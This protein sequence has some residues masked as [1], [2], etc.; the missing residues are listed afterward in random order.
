MEGGTQAPAQNGTVELAE[1]RTLA[2]KLVDAALD[3]E[4]VQ[5]RGRND[6][7]KYDYAR[8]ED[9]ANAAAKALLKHRVL[10]DFEFPR[11][12]H[13]PIKSNKGT[14]G[15]L[16]TVH[17]HLIATDADSGEQIIRK[18]IG[19]GSDYPGDKAAYKAMTGARKY[20]LTHLLGIP[21]GHD[22]DA[23]AGTGR[24]RREVARPKLPDSRVA[25]LK[26]AFKKRKEAKGKFTFADFDILLGSIGVDALRAHSAKA[27]EERLRSLDAGEADALE[28]ALAEADE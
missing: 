10:V 28:R 19:T 3:V 23:D 21:I 1:N 22:P 26:A 5:K 7:Q 25:E 6:Q 9:I 24:T 15:M 8:A 16:T 12:E 18:V 14:D 20:A 27:F 17:G 2:T 13:T 11:V 4:A